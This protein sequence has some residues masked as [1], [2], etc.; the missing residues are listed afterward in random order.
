MGKR[1]GV[2]ALHDI[3][4]HARVVGLAGQLFHGLLVCERTGLVI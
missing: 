2:I 3:P 4:P 1:W